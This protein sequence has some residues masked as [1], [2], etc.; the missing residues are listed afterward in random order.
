MIE[1][2]F[3]SCL[4]VC[5]FVCLYVVNIKIRYTFWTKRDR[6]FIFD[7]HTQLTTPFQMTPGLMTLWP[8]LLPVF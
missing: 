8:W 5:L 3:L 2:Y 1:A 4:L 7:M 6:D